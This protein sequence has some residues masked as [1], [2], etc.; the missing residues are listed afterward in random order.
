M[1]IKFLVSYIDVMSLK[2]SNFVIYGSEDE[3]EVSDINDLRYSLERD[4]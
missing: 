4:S 3:L 2:P 1:M